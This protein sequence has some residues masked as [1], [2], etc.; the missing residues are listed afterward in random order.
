MYPI[1]IIDIHSS[2]LRLMSGISSH[3][4]A[5]DKLIKLNTIHLIGPFVRSPH[6]AFRKYAYICLANYASHDKGKIDLNDVN[7]IKCYLN[8]SIDKN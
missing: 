3:E 1:T 8:V 7:L 6:S 2:A 4:I 5:I